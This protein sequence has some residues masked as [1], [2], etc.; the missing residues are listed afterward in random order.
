MTGDRVTEPGVYRNKYGKQ[1]SLQT[2]EIFPACP[3]KGSP[4]KWEKVEV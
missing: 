3:D 2:N 1:V 4:T